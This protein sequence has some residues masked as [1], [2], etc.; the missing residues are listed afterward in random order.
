[1]GLIS[2]FVIEPNIEKLIF[3]PLIIGLLDGIYL[4]WVYKSK[5]ISVN[6]VTRIS[7][8]IAIGMFLGAVLG[9]MLGT[10]L[11]FPFPSVFFYTIFPIGTFL[12]M[13]IGGAGIPMVLV[14]LSS[15]N[16]LMKRN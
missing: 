1:M 5:D 12:G 4:S 3:W 9:G 2:G 16:I 8:G 10:L 6:M 13:F 14:N 11:S 15:R 7:V